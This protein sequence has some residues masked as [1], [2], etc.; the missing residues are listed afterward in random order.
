M[1]MTSLKTHTPA[2]RK[3]PWTKMATVIKFTGGGAV[4]RTSVFI[5]TIREERRQREKAWH[6]QEAEW[7]R[8]LSIDL[9]ASIGKFTYNDAF[10][11]YGQPQLT[12]MNPQKLVAIYQSGRLKFRWFPMSNQRVLSW[13]P[14]GSRLELNFDGMTK[15]V[16]WK[17]TTW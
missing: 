16:S 8:R 7:Q 15:L 14:H 17:Y 3:D 2:A 10:M 1:K 12:I 9:D 13:F 5:Q 6:Q 11:K 4:H